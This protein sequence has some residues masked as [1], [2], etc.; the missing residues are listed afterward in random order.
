MNLSFYIG[1]L[2]LSADLLFSL[3]EFQVYFSFH[4]LGGTWSIQEYVEQ[5]GL[6]Q[7]ANLTFGF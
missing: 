4:T 6:T 7:K 2:C 3:F 5:V 1:V